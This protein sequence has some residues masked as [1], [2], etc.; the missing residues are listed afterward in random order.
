MPCLPSAPGARAMTLQHF[1]DNNMEEKVVPPK[2]S[3]DGFQRVL[4][5]AKPTVEKKELAVFAR[6]TKEFGEEG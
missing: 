3:M 6:F 2:I 1:S 5:G 4:R